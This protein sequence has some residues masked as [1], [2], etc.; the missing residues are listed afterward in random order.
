MKLLR[1]FEYTKAII[2]LLPVI[3][4]MVKEQIEEKKLLRMNHHKI[5]NTKITTRSGYIFE[6]GGSDRAGHLMMS[7]LDR[8]EKITNAHIKYNKM[9]GKPYD[10]YIGRKGEDNE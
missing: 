3:K 6:C 1:I 5:P 2:A 4:E 10:M 9:R 7:V 8:R